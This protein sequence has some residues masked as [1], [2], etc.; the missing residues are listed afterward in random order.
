MWGDWRQYSREEQDSLAA[1]ARPLTDATERVCP[2]CGRRCVR[3]YYYELTRGSGGIGVLYVWCY[4]CKRYAASR[5]LSLSGDFDFNDPFDGLAELMM[6]RK[7]EGAELLERAQA[8]WDSGEL[9]Q[10]FNPKNR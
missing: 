4:N 8:M 1:N 2:V 10:S 6:I 3:W 9:P 5:G 7:R